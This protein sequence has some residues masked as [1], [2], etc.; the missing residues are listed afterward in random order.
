[1]STAPPLTLTREQASRLQ[2]YLQTYRRYA[3]A[4]FLPGADR[5]TTLR[6]LQM[7]QGKLIDAIDQKIVPFRLIL[8][9]EEMITLKAITAELL[10]LYTQEPASEERNAILA[11]LAALKAS[12]KNY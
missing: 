1:M 9:T 4:A 11:D 6:V 7:M 5:N 10:L 8:T 3:F 2:A 12:L